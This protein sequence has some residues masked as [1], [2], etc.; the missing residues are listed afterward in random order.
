MHWFRFF[1]PSCTPI[2]W[3]PKLAYYGT[4]PPALSSYIPLT[5]L[6]FSCQAFRLVPYTLTWAW[7]WQRLLSGAEGALQIPK[8]GCQVRT[9]CDSH[10]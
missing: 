8:R 7:A 1:L 10:F 4:S 2:V 9:S 5:F 3:L 6:Y